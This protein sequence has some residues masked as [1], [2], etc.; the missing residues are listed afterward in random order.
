MESLLRCSAVARYVVAAN[1]VAFYGKSNLIKFQENF[2]TTHSHSHQK[3]LLKI[4]PDINE[5]TQ[6]TKTRTNGTARCLDELALLNVH[7]LLDGERE[8]ELS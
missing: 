8:R 6:L 7:V 1:V 2:N 4:Q 3:S 5:D